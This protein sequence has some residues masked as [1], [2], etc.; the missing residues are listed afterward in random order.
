MSSYYPTPYATPI[1]IEKAQ[2]YNKNTFDKG[3]NIIQTQEQLP[4]PRLGKGNNIY[5]EIQE[6]QHRAIAK[7]FNINNQQ[8]ICLLDILAITDSDYREFKNQV[9]AGTRAK[10]EDS[11]KLNDAE[12]WLKGEQKSQNTINHREPLPEA[13]RQWLE[14]PGWGNNHDD[15]IIYESEEWIKRF[16]KR[17]I[18]ERPE[19]C[20]KLIEEIIETQNQEEKI[21]DWPEVFLAKKNNIHILFARIT[22]TNNPARKV[23]FLLAP[24]DQN[25][26]SFEI[27]DIGKKIGVDSS[28]ISLKNIKLEELTPFARRSYPYFLI[29]DYKYWL[30]IE[31]EEESNLALSAE[32]E[33]ILQ[34]VSSPEKGRIIIRRSSQV[35]KIGLN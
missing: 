25:P 16:R 27:Q 15:L 7:I 6:G 34:A 10:I 19:S 28:K 32:E 22:T 17:E 18:Q 9:K 8:V 21:S 30:F 4:Y 11:L 35:T 29:A 24:F 5:L 13:M 1:F 12:K 3:K 23:L 14:P 31:R 20:H 2:K 33:Q 26:D